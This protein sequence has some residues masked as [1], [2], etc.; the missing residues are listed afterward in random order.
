MNRNTR[1]LLGGLLVAGALYFV[2]SQSAHVLQARQP[3][4]KGKGQGGGIA[5]KNDPK[6]L[7][8]FQ[9]AVAAAAKSTFRVQCDG[10]DAAFGVAVS[11]DGYILTKA[12]DLTGKITV[13]TRDG[14]VLTATLTGVHEAHDL[15]ML[16]VDASGFTP[17][18]WTPSSVATVGRFVASCGQ[19]NIPVAIGVVSVASRDIPPPKAGGKDQKGQKGQ[20]APSAYL[21]VGLDDGPKGPL[22]TEVYPDLP[23]AKAEVKPGDVIL[24]VLDSQVK[25]YDELLKVLAKLKPGEAVV[26]R[27]LR[28][29]EEMELKAVL[30]SRPGAN[31]NKADAQ[32]NMGSR[33]SN[34]RTGF[35]TILQHDS[36]V[37]PE[38][39]G[40]PLVDVEG[41]VVGLNIARAGRVESYAIP[42]EVIEPLLPDLMSGKLA[43]KKK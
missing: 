9:A 25:D 2:D 3:Q 16:K 21:G 38:D 10:K 8:A 32:N 7:A 40:S 13:K 42:T 18:T 19:D 6:F 17:V 24:K 12:S 35:P 1:F 5:F 29:T 43:P 22:V 4:Q 15:A 26:L 39:C 30:G 41:H 37:L 34:R 27:I 11:T 14:I 33:L 28:G 31:P 23:A 36:V 20:A